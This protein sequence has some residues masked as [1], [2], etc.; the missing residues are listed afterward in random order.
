MANTP[1]AVGF[2]LINVAA[3]ITSTVDHYTETAFKEYKW[4]N[5]H[6]L[7]IELQCGI[8]RLELPI[9]IV[10]NS[11]GHSQEVYVTAQIM[12][13]QLPMHELPITTHF[14]TVDTI[15]NAFVWDY[16]LH[17]PV[18]IRDLSLNSILAINAY[19]SN[20][21]LIGSTTMNFFDDN[22]KLRRGKQ[23]LLFYIG[24]KMKADV[25][26]LANNKTPGILYELYS[27]YDHAFKM[28]K[29]LEAYKNSI[30]F[31]ECN[32]NNIETTQQSSWLDRLS[33]SQIQNILNEEIDRRYTNG[34]DDHVS[35]TASTV[36]HS[37]EELDFKT[38][39]CLVIEMPVLPY[40][41]L[42]EERLYTE[43]AVSSHAPQTRYKQPSN[44]IIVD[45]GRS[46]EFQM[47]DKFNP[48]SLLITADWDRDRENLF[49]EQYR[50]LSHNV[51][52]GRTD[53]SIKPNLRER[54]LITK[55]LAD[56][57]TD[58]RRRLSVEDTELIYKFRYTLVDN[59]KALIK[60]LLAV[61][62]DDDV[63]VKEVPT[64]LSMWQPVDVADAL[65]LLGRGEAFEHPMIREYA[66]NI[67]RS[68]SDDELL[69]YLLQ[70]VQALRYE[71][72]VPQTSNNNVATAVTGLDDYNVIDN[73]STGLSPLAKF[74][75]E[76][77]CNS[78]TVANFFYWYLRVESIPARR[79]TDNRVIDDSQSSIF[80]YKVILDSFIT[81]LDNYGDLGKFTYTYTYTYRYT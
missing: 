53:M 81:Q 57:R 44:T 33:L 68:A 19:T 80:T 46:L 67:L 21:T 42:H 69:T 78:S 61:K 73:L 79:E 36:G 66:V 10:V 38:F 63:E 24:D 64:L 25:S 30:S 28:E 35:S 45:G 7:G 58:A 56:A 74:L 72:I 3:D 20:D 1:Q 60:Y 75:I 47:N 8:M 62:W 23:K 77:G 2:S 43:N 9:D 26:V 16:V 65:K 49:E 41:I 71:A 27:S 15:R 31:T 50:A 12:C 22:G 6:T 40:P 51:S 14:S 4:Y 34:I 18:K 5:S 48:L 54:E 59:K 70:L 37:T 17:F 76:R 52:R 29:L 32:I 55:A 11:T 39:H 13:N